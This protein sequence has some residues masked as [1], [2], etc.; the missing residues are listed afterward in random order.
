MAEIIFVSSSRSRSLIISLTRLKERQ[1]VHACSAS[2]VSH[3]PMIAAA[4]NR[5]H[6]AS[7]HAAT[8]ICTSMIVPAA[9]R[10]LC[11]QR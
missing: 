7:A 5:C 9:L 11:S 6:S 8:C 1:H 4:A 2:S 10:N 3:G